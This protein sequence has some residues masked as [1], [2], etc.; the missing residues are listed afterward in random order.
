VGESLVIVLL[1][2]FR[3]T[4]G[5]MF[6]FPLLTS[7]SLSLQFMKSTLRHRIFG[8]MI[9]LVIFYSLWRPIVPVN[10]LEFIVRIVVSLFDSLIKVTVIVSRLLI[11][12]LSSRI[13]HKLVCVKLR[14]PFQSL[15]RIIKKLL[16][17]I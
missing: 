14:N 7:R 2:Q 9:S 3:L 8:R 13:M 17:P 1:W 5:A 16:E 12:L 4:N 15:R 6:V 10:F 11:I